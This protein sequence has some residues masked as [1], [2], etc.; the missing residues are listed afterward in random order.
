MDRGEES[1]TLIG[2]NHMH[3]FKISPLFTQTPSNL[4]TQNHATQQRGSPRKLTRGRLKLIPRPGF[5]FQE[6]ILSAPRMFFNRLRQR[7]HS[8]AGVL[9]RSE[10][11]VERPR[12]QL[13]LCT[14]RERSGALRAKGDSTSTLT[15]S[16]VSIRN[17]KIPLFIYSATARSKAFVK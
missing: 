16:I 5:S 9:E 13:L 8:I 15:I 4:E 11:P 12:L 2:A 14:T 1:M 7:R 6:L 3:S 10:A 17:K